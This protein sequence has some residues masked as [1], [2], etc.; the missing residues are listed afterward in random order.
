MRLNSFAFY[1]QANT[2]LKEETVCKAYL[3]IGLSVFT[4]RGYAGL[5][6]G[7]SDIQERKLEGL[8]VSNF[9][10]CSLTTLIL[11]PLEKEG[12]RLEMPLRNFLLPLPNDLATEHF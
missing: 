1:L 2:E 4:G 9:S 8:R 5:F 3:Q 6:P 12:M 7:F 10:C 11:A